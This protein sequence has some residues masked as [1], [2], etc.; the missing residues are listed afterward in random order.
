[1]KIQILIFVIGLLFFVACLG[2][3]DA[4]AMKAC[5]QKYSYDTC[6]HTIYN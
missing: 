3:A 4:E 2:K 6:F 5:Q 1:M